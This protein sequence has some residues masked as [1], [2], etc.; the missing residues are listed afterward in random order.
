MTTKQTTKST[1]APVIT[2]LDEKN[3][4]IINYIMRHGKKSVARNIFK[5]MLEALR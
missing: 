3:E 5:N 4:K 1:K 2:L